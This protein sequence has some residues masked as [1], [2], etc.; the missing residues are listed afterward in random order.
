VKNFCEI[1]K[2]EQIRLAEHTGLSRRI[3]AIDAIHNRYEPL[4]RGFI[5]Y[6]RS[7]FS[8][9]LRH[10]Y[11]LP[12]SD[13]PVSWL[14]LMTPKLAGERIGRAIL[15]RRSIRGHVASGPHVSL[16]P[17]AYVLEMDIEPKVP[18]K[19][20]F[21]GK[22]KVKDLSDRQRTSGPS[23]RRMP[24]AKWK[25]CGAIA[26]EIRNGRNV[27]SRKRIG[28]SDLFR[29]H[30][31]RLSLLLPPEDFTG[32]YPPS[33]SVRIWSS[34]WISFLIRRLDLIAVDERSQ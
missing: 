11:V 32:A 12:A 21:F 2:A 31:Y 7:P 24:S 19:L 13:K 16:L 3:V 15:S 9:R 28:F 30:L 4:V 17:G 29:R 18:L 20:S 26:I 14:E 25:K 6:A 33:L 22:G 8:S 23:A 34:G 27:I 5:E 10:G 1:V